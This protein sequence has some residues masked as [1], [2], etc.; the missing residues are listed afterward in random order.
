MS[1]KA[2]R[3]LLCACLI[4]FSHISNSALVEMEWD[5]GISGNT[6]LTLDT[7]TGMVWLDL[8]VTQGMDYFYVVDQTQSGGMFEGFR[9]ATVEETRGLYD[10]VSPLTNID[11]PTALEQQSVTEL[12]N[13]TGIT[14]DNFGTGYFQLGYNDAFWGGN[15]Y[16]RNIGMIEFA[17]NNNVLTLSALATPAPQQ[18]EP[19]GTY[20][21]QTSPVPIPSALLLFS[22]GLIG[23]V[24]FTRRRGIEQ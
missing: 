24:G 15:Q 20:L 16:E 12:L 11:N 18:G 17:P 6:D 23:L 22:S 4:C 9:V 8:T 5:Q 1:I 7:S 10:F 3:H 13:K 2:V 21:V 19:F 14:W